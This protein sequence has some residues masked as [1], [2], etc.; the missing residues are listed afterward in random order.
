MKT[1]IKEITAPKIK[2]HTVK[3]EVCLISLGIQNL[4]HLSLLTFFW[5][6]IL[7]IQCYG[8][9]KISETIDLSPVFASP[10]NILH[11]FLQYFL[12]RSLQYCSL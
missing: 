5:Q 1:V 2:N 9:L 4:S 8:D 11:F 6:R 10:I 3:E 12:G 7:F